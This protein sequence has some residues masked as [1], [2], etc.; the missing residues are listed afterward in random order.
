ML[1]RRQGGKSK[2]KLVWPMSPT[3]FLTHRTWSR[4]YDDL[5]WCSRR[6]VCHH[7]DYVT[8]CT[9]RVPGHDPLT[10]LFLSSF[11]FHTVHHY[12]CILWGIA[13]SCPQDS[14][15]ALSGSW[16]LGPLVSLVGWKAWSTLCRCAAERRTVAGVEGGSG[17]L[18]LPLD[19][20][21]SL[22]AAPLEV[23]RL[24]QQ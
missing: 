20:L 13:Q 2:G 7:G 23:A 6:T 8:V 24:P 18:P 16:Q 19:V 12:V 4:S 21:A 1:R 15:P 22:H 14:C 3:V 17:A 11:L 9:V 10:F 5:T